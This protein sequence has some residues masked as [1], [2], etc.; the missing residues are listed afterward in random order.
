M[1]R[2][3]GEDARSHC[4]ENDRSERVDGNDGLRSKYSVYYGC[5]FTEEEFWK[6]VRFNI[7]N[8]A[9]FHSRL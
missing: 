6:R 2:K 5:H 4:C 8:I 9:N 3:R 7:V 1:A